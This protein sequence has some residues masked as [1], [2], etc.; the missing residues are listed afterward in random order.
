MLCSEWKKRARR[1][2]CCRHPPIPASAQAGHLL[3]TDCL[4]ASLDA[5]RRGLLGDGSSDFMARA[6]LLSG[7]WK[8]NI[9]LMC[10]TM[11]IQLSNP[12]QTSLESHQPLKTPGKSTPAPLETELR[13]RG[14]TEGLSFRDG[15]LQQGKGIA[16]R[17][18]SSEKPI[19][20]PPLEITPNKLQMKN[21]PRQGKSEIQPSRG[22]PS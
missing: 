8:A 14:V 11:P 6:I 21:L 5:G 7:I 15:A 1:E 17:Q 18:L 22:T 12:V 19:R 10:L 4:K 16:G 3:A 9:I 2:R 13:P 20:F